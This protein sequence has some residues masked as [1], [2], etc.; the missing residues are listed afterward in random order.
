MAIRNELTGNGFCKTGKLPKIA[1]VAPHYWEEPCISG[2]NGSGAIFFSGCVMRC[3]FCQNYS[4]SAECFGQYITIEK[5]CDYFKQLEATGVHNINL[6]TPT[7]F[8]SAIA[9]A[10]TKYKPSIPVI[11]NCGGYESVQSLRQLNG[12]VDIYLPDFKYYDDQLAFEYSSVK[13]YKDTAT[14]AIKEMISQTG[15]PVFNKDGI[16]TSGTIIRHLILP[17]NTKNSI[18]VLRHIKQSFGDAAFVSLMAQYVPFGKALE[19]E[20]L[21]RKLTKREYQKVLN[22]LI[23]LELDGFSQEME[24]ATK[25]YIPKFDLTGV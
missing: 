20:K 12:L 4:V 6:V 17:S 7:H 9:Q 15:K 5:L 24:S 13:N 21:N 25:D 22:E 3:V 2:K 16:I 11:Y 1:R 18:S 8:T 14:N 19:I 10:L 23:H